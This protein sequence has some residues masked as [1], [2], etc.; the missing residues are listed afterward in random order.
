MLLWLWHH[1]HLI[2]LFIK[3]VLF[4][5]GFPKLTSND[6]FKHTY[7]TQLADSSSPPQDN[8]VLWIFTSFT[9]KY[10][11]HGCRQITASG[12][13]AKAPNGPK[14]HFQHGIYRDPSHSC[15]WRLCTLTLLSTKPHGSSVSTREITPALKL[16][17]CLDACVTS[18]AKQSS[19]NAWSLLPLGPASGHVVLLAQLFHLSVHQPEV[20]MKLSGVA[21]CVP[22]Y[23]PHTSD[24]TGLVSC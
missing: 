23:I 2:G 7:A 24:W 13:S 16:S 18:E 22:H 10:S 17:L 12:F 8:W 11:A 3:I 15:G 9:K 4:F 6:I 1:K 14:C 19:Q 5:F 20:A 21:I